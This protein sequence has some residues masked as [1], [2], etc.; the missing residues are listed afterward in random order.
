MKKYIYTIALLLIH[1]NY[2]YPGIVYSGESIE[3]QEMNF[4]LLGTDIVDAVP[5]GLDSDI[6][7][8]SIFSDREND[9]IYF[10]IEVYGKLNIFGFYIF[11]DSD[12][13]INNGFGVIEPLTTQP[14]PTPNGS[15]KFDERFTFVSKNTV[16]TSSGIMKWNGVSSEKIN[17]CYYEIQDNFIIIGAKLSDCDYPQ[18][19][20]MFNLVVISGEPDFGKFIDFIPDDKYFSI[21]L[22]STDDNLESADILIYPNPA[23]D[24]V[25][26]SISNNLPNNMAFSVTDIYGMSHLFIGDELLKNSGQRVIKINLK[27][28]ASGN[29]F[30]R[31]NKTNQY[32]MH[33]LKILK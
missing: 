15:M 16:E 30:F 17:N 10:K 31:L 29:Y 26:I 11:F 23:S 22:T 1:I 9:S 13:D 20:G 28:L 18:N 8:L 24:Y 19:D 7:S 14:F 4:T 6:K 3:L 25:F 27:G 21:S 5:F 32:Y 2:F 33:L 12:L